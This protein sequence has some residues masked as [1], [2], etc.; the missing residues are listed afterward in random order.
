[1]DKTSGD[2]K[3]TES[4]T[5]APT[6]RQTRQPSH[7]QNVRPDADDVARVEHE[8]HKHLMDLLAK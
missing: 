6:K 5:P 1:M 4:V 7:G 2:K 3:A 8:R